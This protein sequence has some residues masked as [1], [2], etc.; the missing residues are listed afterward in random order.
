ML[1]WWECKSCRR[2]VCGWCLEEV[3]RVCRSVKLAVLMSKSKMT[4]KVCHLVYG[5]QSI[6]TFRLLWSLIHV[7]A[8]HLIFDCVKILVLG[9]RMATIAVASFGL[10]LICSLVRSDVRSPRGERGSLLIQ[11][12]RRIAS[13]GANGVVTAVHVRHLVLL[14][15]P[16]R[17]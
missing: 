1:P 9:D 3:I 16:G 4:L 11:P 15:D 17:H 7:E 8:T 12:M 2:V 14:R 13:G 10:A 5:Y 6:V